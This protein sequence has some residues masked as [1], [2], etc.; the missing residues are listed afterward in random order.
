MRLERVE[1]VVAGLSLRE[2]IQSAGLAHH[3]K[4]TLFLRVTSDLGSGWGECAAYPG[5]RDPDPAIDVVEPAIVDTV[6]RR[7]G[8]AA[9]RGELVSAMSIRS[10]CVPRSV[11]EQT[12]VAALEMALLDGELTAQSRS[13]LDALG[14]TRREVETGALIGIPAGGDIGS[15]LNDVERALEGGARRLRVKI[16]P[17]WDHQPLEALRERHGEVVVYADANGSFSMGAARELYGLDAYGLRCLEQPFSPEELH[18]HHQLAAEMATPIAL[19]E[20][21][22]SPERVREAVAAGAC[23]VAC[24]KPGRLGGVFATIEAAQACAAGGVECFVGGFFESGL[25]RAVNAA[26]A[27]RGEFGLP[28]DLGDPDH[29]LADN[30]FSYLET[31]DG[32]VSLSSS[33]GLGAVLRPEVLASRT[34]RSRRVPLDG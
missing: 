22:W 18:A 27:G 2:P 16:E 14:A 9:S 29:Y 17:G 20:S 34:T 25:G 19:D 1:A 6:T 26:I 10:A 4:T 12:V 33:P 5:A 24:L 32:L 15:F 11:A 7:L 8:A 23:R 30:P 13:L 21:L 3:D 28:G 31:R